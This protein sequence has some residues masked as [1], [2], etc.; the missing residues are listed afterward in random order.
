MPE[1]PEVE[2]ILKEIAPEI[3]GQTVTTIITR[4][5][6]LR[7][8]VPATLNK[9]IEGHAVQALKRR[10]KYL[11]FYFKTGTLIL[12][13]G[14]SGHLRLLKHHAMPGKHDHVDIFFAHKKHLR[15]NDPRRFGALLWTKNDPFT[16]PL[17]KTL[18]PEP[19]EDHFNGKYLWQT[20]QGRKVSIKSFL[21]NSKIVAGIGN[22]YATEALF[23]AGIHPLTPAGKINKTNYEQLV[24]ACK[25]VLRHAIKSGGTT[26]RDYLKS[27]G[28]PGHFLIELKIYG[29]SGEPCPRCK[30]ALQSIKICQRSTVYCKCCQILE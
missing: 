29:K 30:T 6:R 12:H 5:P 17:L 14:M 18:G 7:W 9:Y 26:L 1:L 23:N 10:G 4:T 2:T 13:L 15:F 16:H 21:M 20:A 8:P 28:T 11:L 19:L 3:V 25:A 24:K 22:I 27:D